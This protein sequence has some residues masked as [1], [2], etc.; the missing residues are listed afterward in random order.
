MRPGG[1]HVGSL[2]G[3][4]LLA[5]T[6]IAMLIDATTG[7]DPLALANERRIARF[8]GQLAQEWSKLRA[9]R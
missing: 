6:T 9:Q 7:S 2:P 1:M 3:L 8:G 5:P 4:A